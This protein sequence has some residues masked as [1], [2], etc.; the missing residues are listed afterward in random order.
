MGFLLD[1]FA[2]ALVGWLATF[3]VEQAGVDVAWAGIALSAAG[4]MAGVAS[5]VMKLVVA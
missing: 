4:M 1:E 5:A 2:G 3:A